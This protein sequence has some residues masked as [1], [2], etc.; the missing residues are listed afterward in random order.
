MR[1]IVAGYERNT[2]LP[3]AEGTEED[4]T[5]QTV[6]IAGAGPVGILNA[7]GLA[8][9]GISVTVLERGSEVVQSPR[10]MVYHWSVLDGLERLGLFDAAAARGFLKQG[11]TYRV[12]ATGEQVSFGLDAL[13]GRV[14]HPYNL[15][16][17]QNALV[18]LALEELSAFPHAKVLWNT[19]VHSV[20]QDDNV[21]RVRTISDGDP[22]V[23]TAQW[24]IGADGARSTVRESVG[25]AFDGHTWPERFVA[26][27]I[28]ID[29][30]AHGWPLTT[31][32]IDDR[33]G[34][35]ISKIDTTNLWR[36]TYCED[37]ALPVETVLDRM[38]EYFEAVFPGIDDIELVA[39][40]PY[41]MHQRA[42]AT[43]RVGRVLLAGD[44]AHA[45]N[46][47]G[48]L[49]LTSG[50]FDTYVLYEALAAVIDGRVSD[51][52][53]DEYAR[54]RR[55]VFVDKVSPAASANKKLVYHSSNGAA[56]DE[57]MAELRQLS[58]DPDALF[59]RLMFPKSLET[60]SLVA[61][62]H[63]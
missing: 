36:F 7:L 16:L 52:V 20:D 53:L 54:L 1:R 51:A 42:A 40:S 48:G 10:A 9:A 43:F 37:E 22:L 62:V 30:E 41:R 12:H 31:M 47:T 57:A 2:R 45:T 3:T 29:L 50:L 49:G 26:T 58:S 46:P 28:R 44:A 15:H 25:I 61:E 13:E 24:L 35:I 8:R 32:L 59:E 21:V 5:E 17:G 19:E 39:F 6:L 11:Y 23:L 60:P 33:Y 34:A 55:E 56:F 63:A 4:M 38:P 14:A 18:E 27:N